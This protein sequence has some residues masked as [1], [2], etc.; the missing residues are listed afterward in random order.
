[1]RIQKIAFVLLALAGW[2]FSAHAQTS[3]PG[4]VWTR[5]RG[6][7]ETEYGRAA[8]VD[9]Q[10]NVYVCGYCEGVMDGQTNK[11]QLLIKWNASG[12]WVWTRT[13]GGVDAE[14]YDVAV[15]AQDSVYVCGATTEDFLGH[16]HPVPGA[17][18]GTLTRFSSD[19]VIQWSDLFG[20]DDETWAG[21]VGCDTNLNVYVTGG[22]YG[23]FDSQ[24][25]RGNEDAFL[26]KWDTD[27]NWQWT[28]IWGTNGAE[29]ACGLFIF[30]SNI[31]VGGDATLPF[32]KQTGLGLSDVF[33]T[34][35]RADGTRQWTQMFGTSSNESAGAMGGTHDAFM[36]CGSTYGAWAGQT[37]IGAQDAFV[38]A[39]DRD[40]VQRWVKMFGGTNN[41]YAGGVDIG[42]DHVYVAGTVRAGSSWGGEPAVGMN[43]DLF[44]ETRTGN[45]STNWTRFWGSTNTESVGKIACAPDGAVYIPGTAYSAYDSQSISGGTDVAVSRYEP[46]YQIRATNLS[47]EGGSPV[48]RW[49]GAY[50][51]SYDLTQNT[52]L[53]NGIWTP[54]GGQTNLAGRESMCAT[55]TPGQ[56]GF[57][58]LDASRSD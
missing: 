25:F 58:R 51:W 36:I 20:S 31:F 57:L 12:G 8:A 34:L 10:S 49:R 33:L 2:E 15:D 26:R 30:G 48:V 38:M 21:F 18:L 47:F 9:S 39:F 1:M 19:G 45:G 37:N 29:E 43:N 3:V 22:T 44:L 32:D 23:A 11:G 40:G 56:I 55:G 14:A 17:N 24:P 53:T 7:S 50:D 16:V 13:W 42:A 54:V 6:S 4:R 41:E 35:W 52:S 27:G 46:A 5:F 28:R